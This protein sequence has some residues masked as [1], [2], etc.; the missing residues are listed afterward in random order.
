M[1]AVAPTPP[2]FFICHAHLTVMTSLSHEQGLL[3]ME[4]EPLPSWPCNLELPPLTCSSLILTGDSIA[5]FCSL[6]TAVFSLG[7]F[8]LEATSDW[9]ALREVLYK[10]IT[11]DTIQCNTWH[12]SSKFNHISLK[13]QS[14]YLLFQISNKN[15]VLKV[16]AQSYNDER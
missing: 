14:L 7:P 8:Q 2:L 1:Q 9:C 12:C 16:C 4:C 13:L 5:S 6:K 11:I 15:V 3:W 10:C